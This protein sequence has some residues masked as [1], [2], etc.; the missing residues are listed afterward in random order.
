ML[1]AR[2]KMVTAD[3]RLS[4]AQLDR[5]VELLKLANT[6]AASDDY[7]GTDLQVAIS[8]Y[9]TRLM[10]RMSIVLAE[11]DSHLWGNIAR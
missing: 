3:R 2:K 7:Q 8:V 4:T 9:A 5:Q 10:R 11:E 1:K 6:L